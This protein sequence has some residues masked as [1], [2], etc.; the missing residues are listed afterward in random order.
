MKRQNKE[1]VVVNDRFFKGM[2]GE[3]GD[4]YSTE[5]N[6]KEG[7]GEHHPWEESR[8]IGKILWL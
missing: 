8:G 7:F 5:Y 1:E 4:Y 2:P 6:D 3:H